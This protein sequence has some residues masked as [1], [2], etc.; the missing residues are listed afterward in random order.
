MQ[1]RSPLSTLSAQE[2]GRREE[3]VHNM[4]FELLRA[5]SDISVMVSL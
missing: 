5:Y 4:Y 3:R 1:E 2:V